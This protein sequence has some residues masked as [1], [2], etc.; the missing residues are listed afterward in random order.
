MAVRLEDV[1][2]ARELL[3][4]V[5]APTPV[6]PDPLASEDLGARVYVKAECLQKSGSFKIR[7]AYH[8]IARLSPEE[9]ARGVIAPSAGNHAQ[10]VALAASMQGIRAVIVMP[11]HAPLTKVVATRR[12]GAE[13]VLWGASFD[14]AVA[15]AHEL[16]QRHGYTYVHAFDDE[17]VIAG[18]GTIGLEL[19]EALPELDVLVVP[20]G[21]G[22]LVGG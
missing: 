2:E 3:Q 9:K 10:G 22:G 21:G 15:H 5:V 18:Q 4:G 20:I 14:D 11:Q 16:Q 12:L 1:L 7:G 19:L 17:K 8:K 13:V 6:L